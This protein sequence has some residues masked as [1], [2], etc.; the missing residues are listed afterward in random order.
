MPALA[1]MRQIGEAGAALGRIGMAGGRAWFKDEVLMS[2]GAL[3]GACIGAAGGAYTVTKNR[4][5]DRF[6]NIAMATACG[7]VC[8]A[9]FGAVFPVSVPIIASGFVGHKFAR[10]TKR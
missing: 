4:G 10:C 6:D 2:G 1:A 5:R 8:G 7:G 9:F 3:A